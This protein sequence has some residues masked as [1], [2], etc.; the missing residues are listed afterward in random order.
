MKRSPG[1]PGHGLFLRGVGG[2]EAIIFKNPE[3]GKL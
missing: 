2:K 3:R 1:L